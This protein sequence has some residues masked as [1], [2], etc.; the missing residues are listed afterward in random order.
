MDKV[1]SDVGLAW[2]QVNAMVA[3]FFLLLPNIVIGLVVLAVFVGIGWVAGYSCR[4]FYTMRHRANLG[5]VLGNFLKWAVI[6]LGI[7]VGMTIVFPSVKPAD[8]LATLGVGSVAIGFAFKDILQ[9]W[10]AGLLLLIRQPFRP[11]DQIV[12][13]SSEGTVERIETRATLIKTYDGRRVI[14]PN[15]VVYASAVVVNTAFAIRR[16]E[17]DLGI[18]YADDIEAA[19]KVILAAITPLPGIENEPAPEVLAWD[20]AAS[21]VV[22]K[23][24]YWTAS[25]R[26]DVIHQK[27]LVVEKIKAALD[28]AG[29]DMPFDTQVLLFHDQTEET[30]GLR[31]TQ[32]EGWPKGAA[33]PPRPRWQVKG[34]ARSNDN[35]NA[36]PAEPA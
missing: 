4:R 17:Y 8:L 33:R 27:A 11:G 30:D 19:R 28:Q 5:D 7:L 31:G 34:S 6:L 16:S 18:G 32:R 12:V 10:M 29:I 22:L 15:S 2:Q 20:L 1:P 9:N 13:E 26:V 35:A 36:K 21:A 14:I 3:G 23:V 25:M 24:R